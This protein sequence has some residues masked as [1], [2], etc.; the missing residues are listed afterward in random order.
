MKYKIG[1]I[2]R[3]K[4]YKECVPNGKCELIEAMAYLCGKELTVEEMEGEKVIYDCWSLLPEWLE[5][6]NDD[7]CKKCDD[8]KSE[9]ALRYNTGK[10][11]W[12][13]VHM[14][15]LVPMIRVLEYG[16]LKYAPFNWQKPM[17]R[18]ELLDSMQRHLAALID[19]N[20]LD[21]ESW[22]T[23]IGHIM[24]NALFYSYHFVK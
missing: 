24:A 14:H 22:W 4:P 5:P 18:D 12:S 11:K 16:A 7:E 15:S 10:P 23:H 6:V 19:G 21:D 8:E 1:D 20:E 2:V 13:L 3:V 17:K 9:C